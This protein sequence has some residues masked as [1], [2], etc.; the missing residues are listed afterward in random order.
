MKPIDLTPEGE[1]RNRVSAMRTGPLP[2]LLVGALAALLAGVALLIGAANEVADGKEEIAELEAEKTSVS[3]RAQQLQP[4]VDFKQLRDQ[5]IATVVGLAESRFDWVRTLQQLALVIPDDV[6][7]IELKGGAAPG[8][9]PGGG[10]SESSAGAAPVAGP[11][12]ALTG[13]AT[14]QDAVAAFLASVR[15]IDGVT[16]VG[17]S[18]SV[19]PES[20]SEG[21]QGGESE[22]R[23]GGEGEFDRASCPPRSFV[24][25]FD[26]IVAF[27][28]APAS[29]NYASTVPTA[30]A[31]VEEPAGDEAS[32][33]EEPVT[34]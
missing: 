24:A 28:A 19:L 25:R 5:R 22:G 8:A 4:Y 12:L 29:P 9:V 11:S 10:D 21:G 17:L 1:R 7:L 16:R 30:S 18:N 26:A 13:C 14:G 3:A 15:Q 6:W 2:F 27:D 34:E 23:G 31:P 32:G 33:G 20:Q